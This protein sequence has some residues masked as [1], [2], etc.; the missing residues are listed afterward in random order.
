MTATRNHHTCNRHKQNTPAKQF[1]NHFILHVIN[2]HANSSDIISC[3]VMQITA[4]F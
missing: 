1:I 2:A 3:S 4:T